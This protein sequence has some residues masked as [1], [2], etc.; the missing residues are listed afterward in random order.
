MVIVAALHITAMWLVFV[1]FKLLPWSW[2]WWISTALFGVSILTIFLALL[3]TLTPSA[4]IVV[5]GRVIEIAPN[6]PGTVTAIS[7]EPNT[8]VKAGTILFQIDPAPYE[9]KVKQLRAAVTEARQKVER[10]KVGVA[11]ATAEV[12]GLASQVMHATK[13]Q[14][15]VSGTLARPETIGTTT[16]YPARI[17][18][19][20]DLDRDTLRLGMVGSASVISDDA[21]PIGVV[22]NILLWVTAYVLYL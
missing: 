12:A 20:T 5:V 7:I 13:R 4:R 10:L 17:E 3:N 15:A 6:V 1:R 16:S 19:P 9:A 18:V 21:G 8:L 22:A 14:I 11:I 2:P